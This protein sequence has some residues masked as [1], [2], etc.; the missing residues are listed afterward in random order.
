MADGFAQIKARYIATFAQK[1]A[2]LKVAWDNKDIPQ[3]HSLLHK[4]S[5]SSGGY[6]FNGLCALCQQ[7]TTLTAK[8][9]DIKLEQL[10]VFLQ[11]IYVEL[12]L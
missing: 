12:Q 3:L 9:T 6:G 8:N 4:L 5:G 11:K 7:A 2:D 1:Q 10:E